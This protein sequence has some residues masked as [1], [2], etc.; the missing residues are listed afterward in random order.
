MKNHKSKYFLLLFAAAIIAIS[1]CRTVQ[2]DIVFSAVD[3]NTHREL[4]ALEEA[5]ILL[6]GQGASR[7]GITEVRQQ[8]TATQRN[9]KDND[10]Q[11]L[12]AAWSGRLFLMEGK[13]AD[14]Q[15]E[16]QRSQNLSPLNLPSQ[17]LSFRLEQNLSRR[18]E[19]IDRSLQT[20]GSLGELLTERGRVLFDLNRFSEA[21][22]AF[23][24]AFNALGEKPW[25]EDAYSQFRV[26]AWELRDMAQDSGSRTVE[27][28][29]QGEITWANLIEITNS[30]TDF[31]RFITA[32][33]DWPV[34]TL[35]TRLLEH[36]F[37]PATQDTAL[38]EWPRSNPSSREIVQRSGA[39]WFLWHLNAENRANRGLLTRYS[40][41]FTNTPNARSPIQDIDIWSPFLDSILGCV[42]SE[43]MSLPDGRN[44]R[45]KERVRGSDFHSM[46]LRLRP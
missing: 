18:L 17:I 24:A 27:I 40:S 4:S 20:E 15:R 6:D 7:Q 46:L 10:I 13:S 26:K 8:I 1:G 29:R 23:D 12:L 14:A 3:D 38:L 34:E 36:S 19:M 22:A 43:F 33:R 39:A 35:F 25:Y 9:V 11:A 32:G 16:Y 5:I 42:E 21:V 31:L 41:R 30:E 2:R 44:F 37:I 28:A 45:P